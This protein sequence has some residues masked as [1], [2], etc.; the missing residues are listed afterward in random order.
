MRAGTMPENKEQ[1][2]APAWQ[3]LPLAL[4]LLG[5]YLANE[6][7]YITGA[8]NV[9]ILIYALLGIVILF[10]AAN[11]RFVLLEEYR[12]L[13][14]LV[15]MALMVLLTLFRPGYSTISV[16]HVAVYVLM[17]FLLFFEEKN[18][19]HVLRSV[20]LASLL[21]IPTAF[22]L[23]SNH[24]DTWAMPLSYAL[25]TPVVAAIVYMRY[26]RRSASFSDR[27]LSILAALF[28][29][30]MLLYGKRGPVLVVATCCLLCIVKPGVESK[31]FSKRQLMAIILVAVLIA[32][33]ISNIEGTLLLIAE[34]LGRIGVEAQSIT[35]TLTLAT[36]QYGADA[37]RG[38]LLKVGI[39]LFLEQPIF[40]H[41]IGSFRYINSG[42][43]LMTYPHNFVVQL[44]DDG[45]IA[46][47]ILV[48]FPIIR[49]FF[50]VII[51]DNKNEFAVYIFLFSLAIPHFL[52]SSEIFHQPELWCLLAYSH[53]LC[54]ISKAKSERVPSDRQMTGGKDAG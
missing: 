16:V 53:Y 49:S 36:S 30:I 54:S 40:G 4:F 52:V 29:I 27:A 41:G 47:C 50:L 39:D 37:G 45:G 1:G 32:V 35:R 9:T 3:E 26:Y 8:V 24:D 12:C 46:L 43:H 21:L 15:F 48:L 2:A 18:A 23:R 20:M 42:G 22:F 28:F 31:G 17:P 11:R 10:Q 38:E 44:L 5:V 33:V 19:I 6:I 51:S 25:A 34:L 7:R 13:Y 14:P